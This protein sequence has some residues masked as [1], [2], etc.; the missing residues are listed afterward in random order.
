[1]K[2]AEQ[3]TGTSKR[4][5]GDAATTS[6]A[7]LATEEIFVDSI[8][9]MDPAGEAEDVDPI[10]KIHVCIAYKTYVAKN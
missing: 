8:T 9:A 10:G 7:L 2:N 5:Q 1:M 3:N 6:G 4:P